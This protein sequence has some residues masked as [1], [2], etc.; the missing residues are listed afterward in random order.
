ME[1]YQR[2]STW[3]GSPIGLRPDQT[4]SLA[5]LLESPSL[6]YN[7]KETS[8]SRRPE[9]NIEQEYGHAEKGA[10]SSLPMESSRDSDS[11]TT[12][13]NGDDVLEE[14]SKRAV[15]LF[16]LFR[17]S[18]ERESYVDQPSEQWLRVATWWLLKA[19]ANLSIVTYNKLP[20]SDRICQDCHRYLAKTLWVI[21]EALS[22]SKGRIRNIDVTRSGGTLDNEF[23]VIKDG[24]RKLANT[25]KQQNLLAPMEAIVLVA[26]DFD[27]SIMVQYP[28]FTPDIWDALS[29]SN[30]GPSVLQD[31][32]RASSHRIV[33]PTSDLLPLSDTSEMFVYATM[34]VDVMLF[35]RSKE[36][37]SFTFP[38]LLSV[39]RQKTKK[40]PE[41]LIASQ[42]ALLN[43]LVPLD[44]DITWHIQ[45]H[46]LEIKVWMGITAR[47]QLSSWDF[48]G[49][50]RVFN[51]TSHLHLRLKPWAG[52]EL[53]FE[54]TAKSVQYSAPKSD[55]QRFPT[56]PAPN[57]V[58]RVFENVTTEV[59]ALGTRNSQRGFRLAVITDLATRDLRYVCHNMGF[60]NLIRYVL[61]GKGEDQG[62]Q[63]SFGEAGQESSI[64]L[65][66]SSDQ[67]RL[68]LLRSITG[69]PD[70]HEVALADVPLR[71]V[72]TADGLPTTSSAYESP[73]SALGLQRIRVFPS[74]ITIEGSHGV[75]TDRI[76]VRSTTLRMRLPHRPSHS[77]DHRLPLHMLLVYRQE[78][79]DLT[80]GVSQTS[81]PIPTQHSLAEAL[82][83]AS[84]P[85]TVRAYQFEHLHEL[86]KFQTA[87]TGSTARYDG[88][89][90][91]FSIA[92]RRML[93]PVYRQWKASIVRL[94]I[95]SSAN[96]KVVKLAAFFKDF[97]HA[98]AMIFE[99]KP[100]DVLE[101]FTSRQGRFGVRLVD[102]K[103]ALPKKAALA[104]DGHEGFVDFRTLEYPGEHDDIAISFDVEEERDK[105]AGSLPAL[106]NRLHKF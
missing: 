67:E 88:Y 56:L 42:N 96:G 5:L 14:L 57:C 83:L 11:E 25:M 46:A 6:S 75:L 26:Q 90:A 8:A 77:L 41:I 70:T 10:D 30:R 63:L 29:R 72:T 18:A 38:C 36:A 101:S 4:A 60:G 64:T 102:A 97:R 50:R 81:V 44:S 80:M 24:L 23:G 32:Q 79:S 76:D 74:S 87:L 28:S 91:S 93:V 104:D 34:F 52:E 39:R 62:L 100:T 20:L 40:T 13:A 105:F 92:R 94:Q 82:H 12:E 17:L 89:A 58:V 71:S 1:P 85:E 9:E 69:Q 47:V 35:E 65:H 22:L 15:N 84:K 73:I 66:F 7:L 106:V 78:Q 53:I 16:K 27:Y 19:R 98:S 54:A 2:P 61:I 33:L 37:P 86:H 43:L 3:I 103:F 31:Q 49:L 51:Y 95:V 45:P 48:Y 59:S 68:D 55:S 99:L 21:E